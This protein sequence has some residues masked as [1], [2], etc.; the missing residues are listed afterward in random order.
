MP[1]T[2]SVATNMGEL[3]K[4]LNNY[5]NETQKKKKELQENT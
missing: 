5:F 1:E 4:N 2:N 3:S